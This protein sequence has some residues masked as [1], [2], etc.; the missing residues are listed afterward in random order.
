MK[1]ILLVLISIIFI[2]SLAFMGTG[3]KVSAT[4]ETTAAET[5]AAAAE[6]TVAAETTAAETTSG[7]P[8]VIKV[9]KGIAVA[10]EG[11]TYYPEW[12]N[13]FEE[14][15]PGVTIEWTDI[16][17]ETMKQQ[18]DTAFAAGDP[19]DI[20]YS[21]TGGYVDDVMDYCYD[22]KEIYTPE[23]YTAM[24][25]GLSESQLAAHI[26]NGKQVGIP[27]YGGPNIFLWNK[28]LFEAAGLDPEKGPD[29]WDDVLTM[30]K[31]LTKDTN[32]DGKIDQWGYGERSYE[33]GA[34]KPE[35]YLWQAGFNLLN[36][37]KTGIGY[38]DEKAVAAFEYVEKL[39]QTEKVA[40]PIGLFSGNTII[41]AFYQQKFAMWFYNS[42][43]LNEVGTD[44]PD[45][46]LGGSIAP[47]GPGTNLAEGRGM[48]GGWGCW[49]IAKDTKNLELVKEFLYS[50]YTNPELLKLAAERVGAVP[51]S[52]K[53]G[54]KSDDPF[55]QLASETGKYAIENPY[56]T[57]INEVLTAVDNAFQAVQLGQLGAKEAWEQ[58]VK[59][60]KA[61]F[62]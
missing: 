55:V 33:S 3:C 4:T 58:A 8:V 29:T 39:W 35:K 12:I 31:A 48:P 42:N 43:I 46:K 37:D 32:N 28:G 38:D 34:A 19:P 45:L 30:A 18:F 26:V 23:E 25:D 7:E 17:W 53:T 56:G 40:V 61:A 1:K 51:A 49:S 59:E 15:H 21:F 36:A 50:F 47:A 11:A 62:E 2:F 6:T 57:A 14:S 44:Y 27:F 5:T 10:N 20:F 54:F 60:G 24:T 9:W 16:P 41:D 52:S 22:F 13:A